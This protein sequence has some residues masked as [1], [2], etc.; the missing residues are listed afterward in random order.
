MDGRPISTRVNKPE[1]D[2][3][4]IV[5]PIQLATDAHL[6]L[7]LRYRRQSCRAPSSVMN[8]RRL[9]WSNWI[10]F[11]PPAVRAEQ[12]YRMP[13]NSQPLRQWCAARVY[14]RENHSRT[15]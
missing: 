4:D 6:E 7:A 1:N 15:A 2:D 3:L 14:W 13:S 11:G 5:E 9:N 10:A 12:W 8:S